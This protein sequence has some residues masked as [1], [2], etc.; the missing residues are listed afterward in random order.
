M[1]VRRNMP[2]VTKICGLFIYPGIN[3]FTKEQADKLEESDVFTNLLNVRVAGEP[4]HEIIVDS[5]DE[6]PSNVLEETVE[7]DLSSLSVKQ[8]VD[9]V[10]NTY[11]ASIL[12]HMKSKEKR[13]GVL[14]AI[15]KQIDVLSD[16]QKTEK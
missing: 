14:N 3:V 15:K 12:T 4:I 10:E 13:T 1:I 8:A 5:N 2:C 7:K 11:S 16:S 9:V 6:K